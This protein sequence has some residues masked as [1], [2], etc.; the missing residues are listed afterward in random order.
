V[1]LEVTAGERGWAAGTVVQTSFEDLA[2]V[3]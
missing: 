3:E 1:L 2:M